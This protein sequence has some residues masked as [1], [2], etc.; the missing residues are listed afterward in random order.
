MIKQYKKYEWKAGRFYRHV[1]LKLFD[2]K[3]VINI[4]HKKFRVKYGKGLPLNDVD[5]NAEEYFRLKAIVD[6]FLEKN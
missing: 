1:I 6:S 2:S 4:N 3:L 5:I